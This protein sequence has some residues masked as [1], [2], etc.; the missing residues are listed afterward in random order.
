MA[1]MPRLDV[2]HRDPK[3][4]VPAPIFAEPLHLNGVARRELVRTEHV[5]G[6]LQEVRKPIRQRLEH[7]LCYVLNFEIDLGP[8][9]FGR[10]NVEVEDVLA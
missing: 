5:A 6:N 2:A 9:P 4:E 10:I 7:P 1:S 3:A 8:T